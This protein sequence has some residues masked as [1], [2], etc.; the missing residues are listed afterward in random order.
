[1]SSGCS[2]G[3]AVGIVQDYKKEIKEIID[4]QKDWLIR[5]YGRVVKENIKIVDKRKKR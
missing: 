2:F 4:S 1:M 5:S 3:G